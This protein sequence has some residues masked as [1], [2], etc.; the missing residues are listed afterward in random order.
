MKGLQHITL[1]GRNEGPLQSY[2]VEKD[3]ARVEK[4]VGYAGAMLEGNFTP[5]IPQE[6]LYF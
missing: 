1:C 5:G 3:L 4:T 6:D 2:E